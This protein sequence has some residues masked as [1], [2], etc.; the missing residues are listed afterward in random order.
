MLTTIHEK[1][2]FLYDDAKVGIF[3]QTDYLI[4]FGYFHF[5]I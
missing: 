3:T 5:R 4:C 2:P 1:T